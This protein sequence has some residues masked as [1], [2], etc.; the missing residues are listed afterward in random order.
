MDFTTVDLRIGTVV[1]AVAEGDALHLVIDVGGGR[2]EAVSHI[3]E[4]YGPED[5][6]GRQVVVVPSGAEVVVLAAVS[7]SQGAIVLRPDRP[8]ANGTQV[9]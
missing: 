3:T 8:V 6:L 5:L 4:N 9:V 7:P 1:E 2:R